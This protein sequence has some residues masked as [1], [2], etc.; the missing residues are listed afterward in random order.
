[1]CDPRGG[2]AML[3]A[4]PAFMYVG[5]VRVAVPAFLYDNMWDEF[6]SRRGAPARFSPPT[7]HGTDMQCSGG[8]SQGRPWWKIPTTPR[9]TILLVLLLLLHGWLCSRHPMTLEKNDNPSIPSIDLWSIC[10]GGG[11]GAIPECGES[12]LSQMT[13]TLFGGGGCGNGSDNGT[14]GNPNQ[15][16]PSSK[17]APPS[18]DANEKDDNKEAHGDE[19]EELVTAASTDSTAAAAAPPEPDDDEEENGKEVTVE[20]SLPAA[21]ARKED[22]NNAKAMTKTMTILKKKMK[23]FIKGGDVETTE[24][25]ITKSPRTKKMMKPKSPSGSTKEYGDVDDDDDDAPATPNN[26]NNKKK[27][28]KSIKKSKPTEDDDATS[29]SAKSPT[30][31]RKHKKRTSST[32]KLKTAA[33][34]G[35]EE[36]A[37]PTVSTCREA[38]TDTNDDDDYDDDNDNNDQE[39]NNKLDDVDVMLANL[40]IPDFQMSMEEVDPEE[41][42]LET[43]TSQTPWETVDWNQRVTRDEVFSKRYKPTRSEM[44]ELEAMAKVLRLSNSSD[45]FSVGKLMSMSIG[46]GSRVTDAIHTLFYG[47]HSILLSILPV[48]WNGNKYELLLLT[49]GFVLKH[50]SIS[51]SYNPLEKRYGTCQLWDDVEYCERSSLFT[52]SIQVQNKKTRYE[53]EAVEEEG[54]GGGGVSLDTILG[55]LERVLTQ[56]DMF[57][58][59]DR[60]D[61]LG[62]QYLRIRKPAFTAAV[63]NDPKLLVHNKQQQQ[64][65]LMGINE[66]D[67]YNHFAPLHYAVLQEECNADVIKGLLF[68]GADP[69]LLDGDGRSAMYYGTF[70]LVVFVVVLVV[71][72]V[73][74]DKRLTQYRTHSSRFR[75]FSRF[76]SA[77]RHELPDDI[78]EILKSGGGQKSALAE[79]ELRGELFG[80]VDAANV[81]TERRRERDRILKDQKAAETQAKAE[82]AQSEMS[83]AMSALIE[84]GEKIEQMD[85]KTQELQAEAKTFGDLAAQL[86]DE[87]KNKKWYQL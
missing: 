57:A 1:M 52:I 79:M 56:H 58:G 9:S 80:G 31:G 78:V 47:G 62:W 87:V 81:Q 32:K 13:S 84:R 30:T 72:H 75:L 76:S 15:K 60:T 34:E 14:N 38:L 39:E 12:M 2:I 41:G 73:Y 21:A 74:D 65:A 82:G 24:E 49:D 43:T 25:E 22:A 26:N 16:E 63:Q 36:A 8:V 35:A 66:L 44:R 77:E 46:M 4:V 5:R 85:Q 18:S 40:E 61:Q 6:Q 33:A 54:G 20:D 83:K 55:R 53:L 48:R 27:K 28:S 51:S 69:N 64:R 37:S 11:G 68:A 29:P 70:P 17:D 23:S 71:V 7:G 86:K 19:E 10:G 59:H 3:A 45:V 42:T 50:Q 67:D